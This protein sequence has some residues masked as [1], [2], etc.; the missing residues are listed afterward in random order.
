[1]RGDVGELLDLYGGMLTPK[2]REYAE[3]YYF[4]DLSLSE[5]AENVGIT[6]PGV[7][8]II[9]RATRKIRDAEDKTGLAAKIAALRG[10]VNE[11]IKLAEELPGAERLTALLNEV[12]DGV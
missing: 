6:A 7:H 11:A 10:G 9:T 8:D 5:I 1:M 2:Q 4:D 12:L 3:M